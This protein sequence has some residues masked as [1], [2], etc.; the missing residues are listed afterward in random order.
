MALRGERASPASAVQSVRARHRQ[1]A[2]P[3]K[4]DASRYEQEPHGTEDGASAHPRPASGSLLAIAD[5]H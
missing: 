1:K 3:R 5:R 2:Q 4:V